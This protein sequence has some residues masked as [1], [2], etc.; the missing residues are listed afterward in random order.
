MPISL[1]GCKPRCTWLHPGKRVG[2]EDPQVVEHV[3]AVAATVHDNLAADHL[4]RVEVPRRRPLRHCADR[5]PDPLHQIQEV[6]V[7]IVV[8]AGP[9][10]AEYEHTGTE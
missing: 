1:C 5:H 8:A 9:L 6:H 3:R 4:R 7:F 10:S 2:V